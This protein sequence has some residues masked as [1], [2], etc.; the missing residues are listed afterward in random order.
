MRIAVLI[1]GLF[2][3]SLPIAACENYRPTGKVSNNP[4]MDE[5]PGRGMFTGREGGVV[6]YRR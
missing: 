6:L 4:E 1:L 2:V 3:M 5:R